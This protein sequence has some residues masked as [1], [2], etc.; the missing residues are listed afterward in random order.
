MQS[1]LAQIFIEWFS[2]WLRHY[3][4]TDGKN[5]CNC[6]LIGPRV[7]VRPL[8]AGR[9]AGKRMQ[10]NT[11]SSNRVSPR[12]GLRPRR[13]GAMKRPSVLIVGAG[14][15]GT[16]MGLAL[17]AKGYEIEVVVTRRLVAARQ[18]AKAFGPGTMALSALQLARF[19]ARLQDRLNRCSL[20]LIASP[21][22]AIARIAEQLA[23]IFKS[24]SARSPRRIALHTSG[25]L[26]ADA[27]GP[28][29]SA[30]FAVG[31]LHPL[32]SISDSRLGSESLA[33]AFFSVEGDAAA[34]RVARSM[35]RDLG[36]R[37]FTIDSRW[38]ALYHA[39]AVTA[40][41][42]MTAL[43][44]IALEMLSHCG[45]SPQRARQV[46]LPLAESTLAN[47]AKQDPARALTGTFKRGDVSTVKKHLA[48]LKS[49]DLPQAL[50][51][52][53]LLGQRSLLLARRHNPNRAGLDEIMRLLSRAAN[54]SGHR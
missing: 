3:K 48:A 13:P 38:K 52:Y 39:A 44:D 31:S 27:L 21:D 22:D 4:P 9:P 1:S 7:R 35:V 12:A 30:G 10:P 34:V 26:S 33:R 28:L 36:G 24:K 40:A 20:V 54:S 17:K 47:L 46:L 32:V 16:A 8:S 15:L 5:L 53:V 2:T 43:F 14:R 41:P 50:A 49:A 23:V 6:V 45:L 42:N 37:S 25:A 19:G 11:K 29:R 51:A 18:A